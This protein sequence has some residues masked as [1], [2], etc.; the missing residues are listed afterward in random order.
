VSLMLGAAGSLIIALAVAFLFDA[1][2]R[3]RRLA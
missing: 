1:W 3:N 2:R